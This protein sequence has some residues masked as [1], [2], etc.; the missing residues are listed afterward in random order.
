[1][2]TWCSRL[3]HLIAYLFECKIRSFSMF[4]IAIYFRSL[5]RK[6]S[7]WVHHLTANLLFDSRKV[8]R[9]LMIKIWFCS[10]LAFLEV[11]MLFSASAQA[12]IFFP[13]WACVQYFSA[14][15]HQLKQYNTLRNQYNLCELQNLFFFS[16]S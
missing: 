10:I 12:F 5:L 6:T 14:L 15:V 9:G 1:M 2:L 13:F 16:F 7:S 8:R 11:M 3:R 4:C